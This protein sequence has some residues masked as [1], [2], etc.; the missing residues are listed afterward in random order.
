MDSRPIYFSLSVK[1]PL[2]L[3]LEPTSTDIKTKIM[4]NVNYS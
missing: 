3:F 4:N 2:N 1:S